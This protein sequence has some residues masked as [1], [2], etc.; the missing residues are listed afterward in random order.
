MQKNTNR[1]E[2]CGDL[3][4]EIFRRKSVR[5]FDPR[6]L[7]GAILDRT[8]NAASGTTP[9]NEIPAVFR[10]LTREQV[11]SPFGKAPHYLGVYAK[12]DADSG[13]NAAFRL[14]Q[15]HLWLS[16]QGIGSC[17]VGMNKAKA[18]MAEADGLPFLRLIAFGT[19]GEALY[20]KDN[21][22]FK[23]KPLS[24]ISDISGMDNILEA[25]RLA[26][27][28]MNRQSWY[29]S[30][31]ENRIHVYMADDNFMVKKIL[32]PLGLADAGIALCHLWL[33]AEHNSNTVS[34][35]RETADVPTH[36]KYHYIGTVNLN[37]TAK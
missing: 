35:A 21:K 5:S 18:E 28:A 25:V 27:S 7:E 17:W 14:Q 1:P 33:A 34:F 36:K 15:M 22:E 10:I 37:T 8:L 23:R 6:Q 32:A 13:I 29:F 4:A 3:Y 26:P 19:P 16:S 12:D 9:L 2:V 24:E 11:G 30:G 20:R 31:G